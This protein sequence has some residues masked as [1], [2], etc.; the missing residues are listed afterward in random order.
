MAEQILLYTHPECTF[1]D[2]LKDELDEAGT[3]YDEINLA[4][5]PD[6]WAE[7]EELTGGERITPVMVEGET[8]SVGF[9]GVG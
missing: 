4:L 2:A 7:L 8:V 9:H 6:K 3:Q 5:S 1:S